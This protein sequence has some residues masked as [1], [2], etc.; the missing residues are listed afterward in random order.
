MFNKTKK[1]LLSWWLNLDEADL[2]NE[3]EKYHLNVSTKKFENLQALFKY[4]TEVER[5]AY[6]KTFRLSSNQRSRGLDKQQM[7]T[8]SREFDPTQSS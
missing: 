7:L 6:N 3:C 2:R 5:K 1:E 4:I 8:L